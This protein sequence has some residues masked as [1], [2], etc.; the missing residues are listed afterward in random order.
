MNPALEKIKKLLRLARDKSATPTEAATALQMAMRIAAASG[1]D[2][3]KVS[4][5]ETS[6]NLTHRTTNATFGE[7]ER[8]ASLIVRKHFNV[9]ALF[10]SVNGKKVVHFYGY[11]EACDLAIYVFVYLVRCAKAAWNNRVNRRLKNRPA[12]IIGFFC[13]IDEM[14]PEKFHQ[15]GLMPAFQAYRDE[16]L[17][18]GGKLITKTLDAKTLPAKS[19]TAGYKAGQQQSINQAIRGTDKPLIG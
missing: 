14:I 4:T 18:R 9:E 5:D 7:A 13:A 3:N 10:S 1:I 15:P 11:A 12:F 19:L 6:Q 16:V 2:L 17:L 8:N